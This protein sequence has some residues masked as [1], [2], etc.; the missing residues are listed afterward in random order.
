M[1]TMTW[2]MKNLAA[3]AV[4]S[5]RPE[6]I[7]QLGELAGLMNADRPDEAAMDA[8]AW[9][10]AAYKVCAVWTVARGFEW[11]TRICVDSTCQPNETGI[12][13]PRRTAVS[14]DMF[15]IEE[16]AKASTKRWMPSFR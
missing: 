5:K 6:V 13:Y 7:F 15:D 10:Y 14:I 3:A 1:E 8:L 9:R 4:S 16:R 11:H 2:G 12:E